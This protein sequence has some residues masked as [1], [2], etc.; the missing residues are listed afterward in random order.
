MNFHQSERVSATTKQILAVRHRT[1]E[2]CRTPGFPCCGDRLFIGDDREYLVALLT[3][4][5][6]MPPRRRAVGR[7]GTLFPLRAVKAATD[8]GRIRAAMEPRPSAAQF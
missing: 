3:D 8:G 5:P 7:D 6:R 1:V 4:R 2:S